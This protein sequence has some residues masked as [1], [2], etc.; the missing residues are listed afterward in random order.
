MQPIKRRGLML[1]LSSPSGAGKSTIA[2]AILAQNANIKLSV[3]ATTRAQRPGEVEGVD[4][5]FVTEKEFD[6]M[7]HDGEMLEY[8]TVFGNKYGT[9]KK[10]VEDAL[11]AG[12]DV[13]FDIDWQGTQQLTEH[14]SD[15]LVRIFILPPSVD[16]LRKRLVTRA[17]DSDDVVAYRMSE[18]ANQMSH[19]QEYDWVIIN[20]TLE[21]TLGQ[22]QSI[23]NS[24]QLRRHRQQGIA[25]FVRTLGDEASK[26]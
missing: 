21:N 24:E 6:L 22:V 16:E 25:N 14:S 20:E 8:A 19:W 15:D 5:F 4:Y 12:Q 13:M 26:Q 9:P 23:L 11:N 10:P 18:S 2:R 7:V 17:Q 3:S 1:V